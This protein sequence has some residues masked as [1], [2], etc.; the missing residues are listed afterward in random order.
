MYI[1][2]DCIL[3]YAFSLCVFKQMD[4]HTRACIHSFVL[5]LTHGKTMFP[6]EQILIN[7]KSYGLVHDVS[8]K[9][10]VCCM[11]FADALI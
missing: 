3:H 6:H 9:I 8:V 7:P 5:T 10:C 4:V 2:M 11:V 1:A